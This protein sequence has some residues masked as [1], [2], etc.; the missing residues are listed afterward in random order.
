LKF[1][2]FRPSLL[3]ALSVGS[4][5]VLIKYSIPS[6]LDMFGALEFARFKSAR[7]FISAYEPHAPGLKM[8]M[9][10]NPVNTVESLNVCNYDSLVTILLCARKCNAYV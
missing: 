8:K 2:Y 3:L 10:Q 1:N 6:R 5:S 9:E 7:T 4:V